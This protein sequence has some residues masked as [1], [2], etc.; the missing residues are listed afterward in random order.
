LCSLALVLAIVGWFLLKAAIEFQPAAPVGIGGALAKTRARLLRG[1]APRRHRNGSAPVRDLRPPAG[2]LPQGPRGCSRS[3]RGLSWSD[4]G[5]E[6]VTTDPQPRPSPRGA[7][8][9]H[10]PGRDMAHGRTRVTQPSRGVP[11]RRRRRRGL[12]GHRPAGPPQAV[13]GTRSGRRRR[14]SC[15]NFGSSINQCSTR[16]SQVS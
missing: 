11:G 4:D 16:S 1:L 10:V 14:M 13:A 8:C 6:T 2:P 5:Y 7:A 9:G 3:L 12:P 15:R